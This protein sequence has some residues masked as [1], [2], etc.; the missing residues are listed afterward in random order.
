MVFSK[1]AFSEDIIFMSISRVV[2]IIK[3]SRKLYLV[4][5]DLSCPSCALPALV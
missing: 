4:L 1:I 5:L 2:G 3:D